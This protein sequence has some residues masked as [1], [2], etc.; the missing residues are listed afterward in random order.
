MVA[1]SLADFKSS[2]LEPEASEAETFAILIQRLAF[3]RTSIA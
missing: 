1:T 3:E 2:K